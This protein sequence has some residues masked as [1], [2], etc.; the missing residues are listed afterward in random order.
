MS[1]PL[2]DIKGVRHAYKTATGPLPVL[3][4]LEV[5]VEEGGFAAVVGHR[6]A[7]NPP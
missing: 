2:S 6:V 3:D 5:A 1:Q 4:G 7:G